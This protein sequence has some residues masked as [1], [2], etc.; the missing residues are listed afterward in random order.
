MKKVLIIHPEG[1]I[2]NNPN[3][4]GIVEILCENGC[5]VD[6][7]SLRRSNIYQYSWCA[8]ASL[9]LL[10]RP[11]NLVE[12]GIFIL[13]DPKLNSQEKITSYIN[14]NFKSYDLVIGVDRGIIEAAIIAQNRQI[15]YGLISYEIFFEEETSREFKQEEIE[16]CKCLDFIVCQDE[17]RAKYLS[18]ENKIALDKII[19]IPVAGRGIK[20]GEKNSYLYDSLGIDKDKKIALLM[21]SVAQWSMADYI[22]ESAKLWSE[23]WVLVVHSR[24]GLDQHVRPYYEKYKSSDNI[25]FSLEPV[26]DPNQ[27]DCVIHSA[28]VGIAFYK[29]TYQSK[30]TGNNIKYLGMS[31]G[32]IATYLQH[33]LPIIINEIGQMSDYVRK[34]GLGLVVDDNGNFNTSLTDCRS[35]KFRLNCLEFFEKRLD[36]NHTIVPL[37]KIIQRLSDK[38]KVTVSSENSLALGTKEFLA[39]KVEHPVINSAEKYNLSGEELLGRKD[40]DGA[41]NAF[42][43]AI[44]VA[45]HFIAAHNNIGKAYLQKGKLAYALK[46]FTK[47][48][49]IDPYD[50]ATV[51]NCG[52]VLTSHGKIEEA[53]KLYRSY[54]RENPNDNKV[55]HALESLN[56]EKRIEGWDDVI[57]GYKKD[58][59]ARPE[60][61]AI[62]QNKGDVESRKY[63][64]SAI[65][66]VYNS[67]R[68]I[69]GCL[70]DLENQTISDRLE[71]IV[72]NSGSQQNEEAVV[73]E[74]QQK[75]D[76]IKYIRTDQRETVYQAWNRGIKAAAGKYITNANTDDR[77][78]ED[79]YERKIQILENNP[80]IGVIYADQWI[81]QIPNEKFDDCKKEQGLI[82]PEFFPELDISLCLVGSQ[83]M[84]RRDLH[85][86]YGLFDES[87]ESA[88]DFDF[89]ARVSRKTQFYHIPD[90][91]GVHYHNPLKKEQCCG[92]N[93]EQAKQIVQRYKRNREIPAR[94]QSLFSNLSS[95]FHKIK[96]FRNQ[97]KIARHR[98]A[99][100]VIVPMYN[101]SEYII[102]TLESILKQTADN[103]EIIVI[104]DGNV[105]DSLEK[106]IRCLEKTDI[107]V[108]VLS[109]PNRGTAIARNIAV[110]YSTGEFILPFDSDDIMMPEMIADFYK[111][112]LN[113]SRFGFCYCDL[114]YFGDKQ[115]IRSMNYP[116]ANNFMW[117]N[118]A[119][120]CSMF[121]KAAWIDASGYHSLMEYGD[122]D[123]DMW[124]EMLEKG[125]KV[126]YVPKPN[127]RYRW[128][129]KSQT[130]DLV[131]NHW[132]H[133][134]SQLILNHPN[135]Y[136]QAYIQWAALEN[137]SYHKPLSVQE[138]MS[139][140]SLYCAG[141]PCWQNIYWWTEAKKKL[142]SLMQTPID[143]QQLGKKLQKLKEIIDFNIKA[144][145]NE[146]LKTEEF[147]A[148]D[149]LVSA[150]VS[151]YNSKQFIRGCLEGLINQTIFK[152]G[153]LEIVVVNSGSEQNEGAV[154]SQFQQQYDNIKYIK[155]E[156]RETIYKSWNR[157][158]QAASGKYL[159][160][161]NTD[162]RL[163]QD[164][165]EIMADTLEANEHIGAIYIDQI[166]TN[167]P[168]ETFEKHHTNGFIERPDFSKE[169]IAQR[170]PCGPQVMWRKKL[171]ELIGYFKPHYEVAG[172]WDFWLRI[173]FDTDYTITHIP[174]LL[175]LYYKNPQGLEIGPRKQRERLKEIDEIRN[176]YGRVFLAQGVDNK[177]NCSKSE[178]LHDKETT[179]L[180]RHTPGSDFKKSRRILLTT[181]AAP[182]QSPFSTSEKR[183]PI[184]IGFLISVLRNGGHE[185]FFIDNYLQPTNFLETDWLQKNQID[186]VGIYANTICFRD[187]LR[188]MHK[189][190]HLRQTGKWKGRIIV[191]GPHTT[192]AVH[193]IPDFVDYVVQ[194]EGEHAILDIVEDKVT[195]RI[196]SY[197]RI[198]NL[199]E[200]PMPA[201]DYFVKLPYNWGMNFLPETPVFTMNTSRGCPFKCEFCSV[202]SIWGKKYTY[203]SAER[204]VADIE[205]LIEHY[206]V[207][208]IYF[209]EDN[210]TLNKERLKKFCNLIIEKGIKV[211]WACESRVSNLDRDIIE[212]MSRAGLKGF[213]FGVESGSQRMLN[214]LQK[215]ITVEQIRNA[216]CWCHEF[217]VKA[218]ASTIVGVPGET[219]SDR[220]ETKQ[221]LKEIN[222]DATWFNVFVGIPNSKLYRFALDNTLYEYIDDR[223]LVYLQGHNDRAQRYYKGGFNACIPFEEEKKDITNKPK[224]SVLI[225]VHN[226]EQF[227]EEALKSIYNQTYQDFEV[228]IVDDGSTDRTSEILLNLKDSRTFIYRNPE[229]L[230][231]T[232]SLNIG[233]KLCRGQYVARMD[234]DDISHPQRFERQVKF[235]DENP[236]CLVLGCWYGRIDSNGKIW[237]SKEPPT[238]YEETKKQL[239][240]EACVGHGTA[241]V[242]RAAIVEVGGYN[243]E[244]TYAQDYDLWLRLSEV[245]LIRNLDEY[246]YLLR[247]WPG[248]ISAIKLKEQTEFAELA[249]RQALQ[250]RYGNGPVDREI[251][252]GFVK[253][254]I[255]WFNLREYVNCINTLINTQKM[256]PNITKRFK[257]YDLLLALAYFAIGREQQ[258]LTCLRREIQNHNNPAAG[259]FLSDYFEKNLRMDV[260]NWC[261]QNNRHYNLQLVD[262]ENESCQ[263]R[264]NNNISEPYVSEQQSGRKGIR[265][266]T[267]SKR[268]E[269]LVSVIMPAYNA[270]KF[271]TEAVQSVL[272]QTYSNFELVVV[273][274]GSTDGT[275][276]IVFSFKDERIKYFY[277]ENSGLAATHNTGIKNSKGLF[278]VKL[279][280]DDMMTADFIAAHLAEFEKH[281]D[282]DLVYCDDCLVEENS[283]PI[284]V[285]ERHEYTDRRLLIRDLFHSGFPVVPFR[286]CIRRSV[287]DKIGFFDEELLVGEDYDMMRRFVK[288]GLKIH[289]LKGA[290]YLRR[291]TSDSLSRNYSAQKA[292]CHFDVIKRY[293]DT[294][295]YDELFPDVAWNEIAPQIR[296]LHAKC[297]AA[298]TYLAIGKEYIK[299]NATECSKIALDLACSE[300]NDC[301]KMDPKNQSLRQLS[302][303][304]KLI[305]AKYT[306][307]PQ[308]VVS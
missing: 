241:I 198:K 49:K 143:D 270:Q 76:N 190:E 175:G 125:W 55:I 44:E 131:N 146:D 202:G 137:K 268:S 293:I 210:F 29:P 235:L 46:H 214:L 285:I 252:Y 38:Q 89:W 13:K 98:S 139:L 254:A 289:H 34:Y 251:S 101:S 141:L 104:D 12:N 92:Y 118:Q 297:L 72:V 32:K 182:T 304:F 284:R 107:P 105:D 200:L 84:W 33:G 41:L 283:N 193:T 122:A 276:N 221:L 73:K 247:S 186:F 52:Q 14:E 153:K 206:G 207:K 7:C 85:E 281:P 149:I 112:L 180:P 278:L 63:L 234:A 250:R 147:G 11:E 305:R 194:G 272:N 18:I 64:V 24:Y 83:P 123:W 238:E 68:F 142:C 262:L 197:P 135:L 54:L 65:V 36:L 110:F 308:Q 31:S 115:E 258:C 280:S 277:H 78:R 40:I 231:L 290:L 79:A 286:T 245:G 87:L 271:I 288:H 229:N 57:P 266:G 8:G 211:S 140:L 75:Y 94:E 99:V 134:K 62:Q 144:K 246:L 179:Y 291:M 15:P 299:T 114:E 21:G 82:R 45:P 218:I 171:H 205:Y 2:N 273:D 138:T 298:G 126:C 111:K 155:I 124:L 151:A 217:G 303:K 164:A 173:V 215:G 86:E 174:E 67:Q 208:G 109:I 274:D 242:R 30:Y 264:Q 127:F 230:G 66:S 166:V 43:K 95:I 307:A 93:T 152:M 187:T 232:K 22:L 203:F 4:T 61:I 237:G 80:H 71:I 287:F 81:S 23:D 188:M 260:Q 306:E 106:V 249:I 259:K 209:R 116:N 216:F 91:L 199:D 257:G 239:L 261:S 58:L 169:V 16:A 97:A 26:A 20:K 263:Q 156:K 256:A 50:L 53:G 48:L 69:R 130:Y 243:E 163:R 269:P 148:K 35:L 70:E 59:I 253:R 220:Q 133:M 302:Q 213:Y 6:I 128:H 3:L 233:L 295:T 181:S 161:A 177:H 301:A 113:N 240:I 219:Q 145:T 172:D 189:L 96:I 132:A 178:E 265:Q 183:P 227:I 296:Q 9:F 165:L 294:F 103:F 1:N 154:V 248:N 224:V 228:V 236:D 39:E 117:K 159:V 121:R 60:H 56:C 184:G 201:W 42:K 300:L 27:L 102:E 120:A 158:A 267:C 77:L 292:K 212:L 25:Y 223:G 222:P 5:K 129:K 88:G 226:T 176:K 37:L 100:S 282:V 279:D 19:N 185:V 191:G 192:V 157:G 275:K 195:Q 244:Y 47:A 167:Y 255:T 108:T 136:P 74:F 168:N 225:S 17:L 160:N 204:I 10:D 90:F 119:H 170:N 150:I 196:V 162:D 28:D 51:L